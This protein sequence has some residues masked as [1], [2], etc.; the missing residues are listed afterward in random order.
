MGTIFRKIIFDQG[1]GSG[2]R[3][4]IRT[5]TK[6]R[7]NVVILIN[8]ED[9]DE[10]KAIKEEFLLTARKAARK[11]ELGFYITPIEMASFETIQDFSDF[12]LKIS[13][14]NRG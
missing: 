5:K 1:K 9:K 11:Q 10:L 12:S 7:N 6:K 13:A 4:A 8:A 2:E 14:R 3:E